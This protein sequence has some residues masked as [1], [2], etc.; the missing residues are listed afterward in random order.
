[1]WFRQGRKPDVAKLRRR[2]DLAALREAVGYQETL[3]DRTG[4]ALDLG[5]GI[6]VQ[7]VIALSDFYGP[8]VTSVLFDALGDRD[9]RVRLAA[10]R[11]LRETRSEDASEALL[12]ALAAW[13]DDRGAATKAEALDA[14][15]ELG[16]G[17]LPQ[18][19]VLK[20]IRDR[21]DRPSAAKREVLEALFRVEALISGDGR[22]GT[23]A[24]SVAERVVPLLE[25]ESPYRREHAETVLGWVSREVPD[26]LLDRLRGPTR[27]PAARLLGPSRDSRAV[28]PLA[29]LLADPDPEVRVAAARSLGQLRDTRAVESLL[30]ATRDSEYAVREAAD[31]A[32]DGMG[33]AAV[34]V[35]LAALVRPM[36]PGASE[37]G[38]DEALP[39]AERVIGRLL[40]KGSEGP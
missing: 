16:D 14:L 29:H 39:W 20:L 8:E 36:L 25:D 33:V 12:Q 9:E 35:G 13:P 5:V 23:A 22:R 34:V 28:E 11:A 38:D 6:R 1:V 15:L 24:R 27:A 18:R 37:E 10:V 40:T 3:A 17:E 19:F 4:R 21:P 2:G 7:A 30:L 26:L 31:A 32:L